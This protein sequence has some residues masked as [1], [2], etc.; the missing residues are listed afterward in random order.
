L[1]ALWATFEFAFDGLTGRI[2]TRLDTATGDSLALM[3]A[4]GWLTVAL[5][6]LAAAVFQEDRRKRYGH[7]IGTGVARLTSRTRSADGHAIARRPASYWLRR[8][9]LLGAPA[10]AVMFWP[11]TGSTMAG[12]WTVTPGG[13]AFAN[14]WRVSL[15]AAALAL[16][17]VL[18]EP[19]LAARGDDD[20]A[21][22]RRSV[23]SS[24]IGLPLLALAA[25][26]AL[27]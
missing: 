23:R 22:A 14:G 9:P 20:G 18:A 17:V 4:A 27:A 21:W 3:A 1:I 10:L 24:A 25:S 2:V 19:W 12:S 13:A 16:V 5:L 26:L 6:P 8:F 7:P 15:A 11:L